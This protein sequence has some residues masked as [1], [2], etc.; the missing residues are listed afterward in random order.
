MVYSISAPACQRSW[1]AHCPQ[2]RDDGTE[3]PSTHVTGEHLMRLRSSG[4]QGTPFAGIPKGSFLDTRRSFLTLTLIVLP[5]QTGKGWAKLGPGSSGKKLGPR[6]LDNQL[7]DTE[8]ETPLL[9][10]EL[11]L[12]RGL[13]ASALVFRSV[14]KATDQSS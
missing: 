4:G 14:R 9:R 13:T 1:P 7:C 8:Q 5:T 3:G 10:P 12:N 11:S 6:G 2:C